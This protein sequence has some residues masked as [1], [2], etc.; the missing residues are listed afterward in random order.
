MLSFPHFY[1][2]D[3]SLREAVEGISPPVAEDH[4]LFID[5][6]PVSYK[7]LSFCG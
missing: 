3:E 2:A 1:L 7:L 4:R 5:V 6:Q